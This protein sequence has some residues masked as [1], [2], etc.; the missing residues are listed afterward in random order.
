MSGSNVL[1]PHKV[2]FNEGCYW[3]YFIFVWISIA[4][5]CSSARTPPGPPCTSLGHGAFLATT[6]PTT[7]GWN[8]LLNLPLRPPAQASHV[9]GSGRINNLLCVYVSHANANGSSLRWRLP[10]LALRR[11]V[12]DGCDPCDEFLSASRHRL[13][14]PRQ[15]HM[16]NLSRSLKVSSSL[17]HL[18]KH[19]AAIRFRTAISLH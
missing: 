3:F 16:V 6:P 12:S 4:R 1:L 5:S 15:A 8:H 2:K 17:S 10:P 18:H 7:T 19:N 13:H 14:Y 11:S 9:C